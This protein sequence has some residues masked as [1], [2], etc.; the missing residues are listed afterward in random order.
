ML[1]YMAAVCLF[2]VREFKN[3]K[4]H[5]FELVEEAYV[6]GMMDGEAFSR[7]EP[8]YPYDEF[9]TTRTFKIR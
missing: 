5:Y 4:D 2:F 6:H 7:E 8:E 9:D 1:F 3:K